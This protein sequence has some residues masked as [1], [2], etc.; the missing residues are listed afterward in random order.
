[1]LTPLRNGCE[2]RFYN[3]SIR[4]PEANLND[5]DVSQFRLFLL[6][7]F[8]SKSFFQFNCEDLVIIDL[9]FYPRTYSRGGEKTGDLF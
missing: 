2:F 4:N 8:T 3:H 1:M 5:T 6:D 7:Y 9:S